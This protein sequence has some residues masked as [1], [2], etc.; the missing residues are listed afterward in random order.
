MSSADPASTTSPRAGSAV[1]DTESQEKTPITVAYGDGIGPEIMDVTLSILEAA[2]ARLDIETIDIG[3]QV[4]T[5]GISAGIAPEA[6]SRCAA[7]K[8]F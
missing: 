6:W 4:Y 3:E 2:G 5:R 7:R 8:S 1:Q